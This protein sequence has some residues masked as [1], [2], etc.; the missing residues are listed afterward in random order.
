MKILMM[1]L[2][3]DFLL[4]ILGVFWIPISKY[5]Q[6]AIARCDQKLFCLITAIAAY[7][8]IKATFP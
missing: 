1:A 3:A 7:V 8:L 4:F 2:S 5:I 6:H